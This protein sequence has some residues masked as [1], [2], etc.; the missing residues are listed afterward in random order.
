[1]LSVKVLK[2]AWPEA[3]VTTESVPFKEPDE[4]LMT[5]L[6]FANRQAVR[7]EGQ[8]RHGAQIAARRRDAPVVPAGCVVNVRLTRGNGVMTNDWTSDYSFPWPTAVMV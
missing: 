3:L 2:I 5:I 6:A 7:V 4:M 8:H 1:M